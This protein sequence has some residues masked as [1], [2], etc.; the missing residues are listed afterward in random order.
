MKFHPNKLFYE[1]MPAFQTAL[2]ESRRPTFCNEGGTRSGKTYD[3]FDLITY[4]CD[5]NRNAGLDVYILRDTL[6]NN[7]DYTL[8]EWKKLQKINNIPLKGKDNP[9]PEYNLFGNNIYFRGLDDE[10]NTEAYPSD[11]LFFNEVLETEKTRV[12]GLIM[13]CRLLVIMDWNPKLTKHWV[14]DY[15]GRPNVLFTHSTYKDNKHLEKTIIDGIESYNPEIEENVINKTADAFRWKVYGLG[16]RADREGNV[17]NDSQL[18]KFNIDDIDIKNST[19]LA[20]CDVADQGVDYL[21]FP[22]GVLIGKKT[23]VIDVVFTPKDSAYTIPLIIQMLIKYDID[24]AIFESNNHG[25]AYLKGLLKSIKIMDLENKTELFDKWHLRL[26]AIPN[27]TN[28]HSRI[29]VQADTNIIENFYFLRHRTGMYAEY[30]DYLTMYKHDKSVK[31]DDSP[32]GTAG[33]SILSQKYN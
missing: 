7:R 13:R 2:D 33:L 8:K 27:T 3:T 11:I 14:F 10:E 12:E 24:K 31:Q 22:V 17:F 20:W 26:G 28:K 6:V 4:I 16:L 1:M 32:D 29:V 30:Y 5:H 25:L 23:Y 21:C 15:E 18:N 19:K 9:K